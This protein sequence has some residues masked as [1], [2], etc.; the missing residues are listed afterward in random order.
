MARSTRDR[1][2][3]FSNGRGNRAFHLEHGV[4]RFLGLVELPAME[5]RV[6]AG[7]VSLEPD[8]RTRMSPARQEVLVLEFASEAKL[9][10]PLEQAYLVS[11][12]VGVGKKSP[13]LSSLADAKW[14]R[15]KKNAAASI[16]D[17]AGKM[18]SV[19]AE[20]ETQLGHAFGFDTKWQREFEHSFPYRETPDQLTAIADQTRHG[21]TAFDGPFDLWRRRLRKNGGCDSSRL[22]SGH[23]RQTSG[24][25]RAN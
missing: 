19:Q 7:P 25:P 24:P 1:R 15:A 11:R 22:Q 10:V 5:A 8:P 4:G 17:Y 3:L 16:F 2:H 9:Y 23:G 6:P 21:A 13:P 18:L 12:Y 14:A 20:R